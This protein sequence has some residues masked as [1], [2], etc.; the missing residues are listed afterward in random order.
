[1]TKTTT[2]NKLL[3]YFSPQTITETRNLLQAASSL[4]GEL[5]GAKKPTAKQKKEPWWK[6]RI[7]QDIVSLRKDLAV[8]ES[9]FYG[10]WKNRSKSKMEFLNKK[11][12]LKKLGFMNAIETIRQRISAKATKIKRYNNRCQQFQQNKLFQNDQ[13]RFYRS[14]EMLKMLVQTLKR[15]LSFGQICG[16]I[17]LNTAKACGWGS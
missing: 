13:T 5:L 6:R 4:V 3:K 17:L 11:Y 16:A 10:K 2:V 12:H 1:M 7:E 8:I 14:L 9:W 15:Q